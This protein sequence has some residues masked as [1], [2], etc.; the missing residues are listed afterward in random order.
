MSAAGLVGQGIP[1]RSGV[2]E[3]ACKTLVTQRLKCS[4]MRWGLEG[5]QAILT[6]RGWTQSDRFDAAWAMLAATCKLQV[7][8]FDNVID[9]QRSASR[10]T[11]G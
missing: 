11:S 8:A 7:T 4:G 9:I 10:K 5:G 1:I 6:V 2:V 3:A